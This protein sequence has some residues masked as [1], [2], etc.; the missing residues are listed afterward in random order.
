MPNVSE[1]I[2]VLSIV[3]RYL[4]HSRIY[5]FRNAPKKK[6]ILLGSADL[7]RRNLYNRVEVVFPIL[8]QRART[9]V[10]RVLATQLLENQFAWELQQDGSYQRVV[11]SADEEVIHSQKIF[12][13][14]NF[15]LDIL[16]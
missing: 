12:M 13:E 3:G 15:G 9:K 4:E 7:M 14:S 8:D 1:N 5:Y 6:Q 16:P 2:R 10:L 11:H